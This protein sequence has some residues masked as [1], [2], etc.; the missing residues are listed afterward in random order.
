[1]EVVG[2]SAH[3][4]LVAHGFEECRG[5]RLFQRSRVNWTLRITCDHLAP[6]SAIGRS[7]ARPRQPY[8]VGHVFAD[9]RLNSSSLPSR[10]RL[11]NSL[12]AS[13][14]TRASDT[15]L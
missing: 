2:V 12:I 11:M 8:A 7:L 9:R 10:W 6:P 1:V 5:L 4:P 13:W 3:R 15:S 14:I